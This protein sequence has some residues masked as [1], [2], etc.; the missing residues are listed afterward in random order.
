MEFSQIVA[1]ALYN[2]GLEIPPPT[3][4]VTIRCILDFSKTERVARIQPIRIHDEPDRDGWV[5][6]WLQH[7]ICDSRCILYD[8]RHWEEI[9]AE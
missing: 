9:K 4:Q 2:D 8:D 7:R 5:Y 6:R 3:Q 1:G